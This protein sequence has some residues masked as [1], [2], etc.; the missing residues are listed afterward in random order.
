MRGVSLRARVTLTGVAIVTVLVLAVN[1][2]V[3][4]S[5]RDRL[6]SNLELVLDA[7]EQ[8]AAELGREYEPE[9]LSERLDELGLRAVVRT[10]DGEVLHS[11][12]VADPSE[13]I[14]TGSEGGARL[15]SRMVLL[16]DGSEVIV[17]A[18]RGGIDETLER[19]LLLEAVGTVAAIGL[20]YALF[21]RLSGR[22]LR[23]VR[24]VST[25]ARRISA[26]GSGERL[27][28]R[29]HDGDLAEM[30]DAFNTMLDELEAALAGSRRFLAD[31][32]HQLRTPVAGMR[33]SVGTLMRTDDGAERDRMLDH[34]ARESARTSRLL[35][36]LLRVARLDRAEPPTVEDVDLVAVAEE[37][38]EHQR[39]LAPQLD[40]AVRASGDVVARADA[41]SIREALGNLVD[42]AA[43]HASS[44]VVVDLSRGERAV[45]IHVTDDGPGVP[46][47]QRERIFER[48]VSLDGAG[49]SGLGL[50]IAR[51]IAV[52]HGGGLACDDGGF[53]L[54]LPA[55]GEAF[56]P[57]R[58]GPASEAANLRVR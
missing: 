44:M 8:L 24:D 4:L 43:R 39:A 26:G 9:P 17:A 27:T 15:E 41:V 50:P 16:P 56:G 37:A 10:P 31:A 3:Y 22:I 51:A 38:V 20:A 11:R 30:V 29:P 14:P 25:T 35:S 53:A 23:P 1:A 21:S 42:N 48:F 54:R 28:S 52:L 45:T 34:L 49:G 55:P 36:S 7:R 12:G 40:L 58:D 33:A 57:P 32:A 19:L 5:L 18:S 13:R 47:H 6:L 46:D 2:F